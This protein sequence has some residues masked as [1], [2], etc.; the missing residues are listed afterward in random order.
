M[1]RVQLAG[2]TFDVEGFLVGLLRELRVD[3]SN[4]SLRLHDGV[5]EGGFEFLNRDANDVRYQAASPELDGFNFS[6]QA[7]GIIVRVGPALYRTRKIEVNEE[8]LVITNPVGTA[9]NFYLTLAPTITSDHTWTGLHTFT[10]P[11]HADAGVIGNITGDVLGDLTGDSF[12][13]HTGP[14]VGTHTGPVISDSITG[15]DDAIAENMIH[16]LLIA[17]GVPFGAILMWSGLEANIPESWALC[18]GDN[19]TPDLR[20]RFIVGASASGSYDPGQQGGSE[21]ATGSGTIAMSGAHS[22][23]ITI[24]PHALTIPELPAHSHLNGVG[25][26]GGFIFNRGVVAAVPTS[27]KQPDTTE[28]AGLFEGNTSTVGEGDAHTHSGSTAD[29]GGAHTHDISLDDVEVLPPYYA[30]C[31]IMKIAPDA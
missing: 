15:G 3:T 17:R 12:G 8:N 19:G 25:D 21:T 29:N 13:T 10:Q 6:A 7:K 9:G 20:D 30:L 14:S 27:P 31:F 5:K 2:S 28:S 18:D 1:K 11:I 26:L 4:D 23:T 16:S 22:H 24:A